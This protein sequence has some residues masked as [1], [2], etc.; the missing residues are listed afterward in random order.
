MQPGHLCHVCG[1]K[2]RG[3]SALGTRRLDRIKGKGRG[4]ASAMA[5]HKQQAP[6]SVKRRHFLL[7]VGQ[8]CGPMC[9]HTQTREAPSIEQAR[10]A[11]PALR[12]PLFRVVL[13][14]VFVMLFIFSFV[15]FSLRS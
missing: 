9:A 2:G 1:E 15:L 3:V 4:H 13:E 10:K 14:S 8:G 6:L 5:R 11:P 12:L 7:A